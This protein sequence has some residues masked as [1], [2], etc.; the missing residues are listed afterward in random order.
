MRLSEHRPGLYEGDILEPLVLSSS[1]ICA[2]NCTLSRR[3]IILENKIRFDP[4]LVIGEDWDF[5]IQ[6]AKLARFGYIDKMTCMYRVHGA[7]TTSLSELAKRKRDLVNGRR[8]VLNAH[9]FGRLSLPTRQQF[10]YSLLIGLLSGDPARQHD[11]LVS[12]SFLA[13]PNSVQATLLRQVA[14]DC[15]LRKGAPKFAGDCLRAALS[16]RPS[17]RKSWILLTCMKL[18]VSLCRVVLSGWQLAHKMGK[19]MRAFGKPVPK[20]APSALIS[21]ADGSGEYSNA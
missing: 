6:L 17:D 2:I 11:I 4:S 7:N 18:D 9:W 5:W 21:L 8:K 3:S 15:L 13:M 20:P 12:A 1:I 10:F 16:L 19:K 14:S